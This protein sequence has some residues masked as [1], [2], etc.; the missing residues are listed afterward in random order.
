MKAPDPGKL[1]RSKS[2]VQLLMALCSHFRMMILKHGKD[3]VNADT[4][5]SE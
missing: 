3:T 2:A 1:T 4:N 5:D